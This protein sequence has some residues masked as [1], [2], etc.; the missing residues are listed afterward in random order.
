LAT[1]TVSEGPEGLLNTVV[2][3]T[4][5]ALLTVFAIVWLSKF[6]HEWLYGK[7]DQKAQQIKMARL[8]VGLP[9]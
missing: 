5:V 2:A 1:F 4:L 6:L 3:A 7:L 8:R 9:K